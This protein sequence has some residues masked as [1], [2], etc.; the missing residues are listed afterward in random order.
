MKKISWSYLFEDTLTDGLLE[1]K[2]IAMVLRAARSRRLHNVER[3]PY[4]YRIRDCGMR[5]IRSRRF[6]R[7]PTAG[8]R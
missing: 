6:Q 5:L 1:R 4:G 7:L 2:H 3:Y 8:V